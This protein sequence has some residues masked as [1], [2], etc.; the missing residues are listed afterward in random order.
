[1]RTMFQM[2]F[3]NKDL[4]GAMSPF[5]GQPVEGPLS[6]ADRN[7]L[8]QD[9]G[10]AGDKFAAVN[11]WIQA[12]PNQQAAL[13]ADYQNFQNALANSDVFAHTVA[14]VNQ[15]IASDDRSLWVVQAT[16]WNATTNWIDAVNQ[17]YDIISRHG[18]VGTPSAAGSRPLGPGGVPLPPGAVAPKYPA[19]PATGASISPLAVGA[20]GVGVVGLIAIAL[21]A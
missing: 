9:I 7:K 19:A 16:D 14:A 5:M 21:K 3:A 15:R 11:A 18:A 6:E 10:A 17:L 4:F 8:T 20:I 13:G 1:M 2:G 12:N